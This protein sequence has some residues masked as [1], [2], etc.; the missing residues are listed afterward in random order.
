MHIIL[1]R[2]GR[3]DDGLCELRRVLVLVNENG[4]ALRALMIPSH[5]TLFARRAQESW[6][7]W[8][9]DDPGNFVGTILHWGAGRALGH[10]ILG[11]VAPDACVPAVGHRVPRGVVLLE[12]ETPF[13]VINKRLVFPGDFLVGCVCVCV[14]VC[15]EK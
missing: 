11:S 9:R 6:K 3:L 1:N 7:A 10:I 15:Q 5:Q 4:P 2:C 12:V 13:E 14:C 8:R